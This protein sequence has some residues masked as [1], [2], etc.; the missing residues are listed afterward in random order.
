MKEESGEQEYQGRSD[1][2]DPKNKIFEGGS[3]L[4]E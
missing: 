3:D 2:K 1:Q 4:T